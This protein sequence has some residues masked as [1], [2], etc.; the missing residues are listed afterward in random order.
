MDKID[1]DTAASDSKLTQNVCFSDNPFGKA[2]ANATDVECKIFIYLIYLSI[3]FFCY[4][5]G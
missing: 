4:G 1:D 2:L 5:E 3:L